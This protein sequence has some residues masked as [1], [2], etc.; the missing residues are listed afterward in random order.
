[1]LLKCGVGEDSFFLLLLFY[2][3][4][5][6]YIIVLV[7]PNIKMNPSQVYMCSPSWTLLPPPSPYHPSGSS[8]CTSPKHPV[9][10]LKISPGCL[11]EGLML[12]LKTP[13]LWPPDAKSWLIWKDPDAGKDWGQEGKGTTEDEM[14]GW[15]HWLNGHGFGWTLGVGNG[16]RGLAWYGSWGCKES[17]TTERLNWT[18]VKVP[19]FESWPHL[20]LW[21]DLQLLSTLC[22]FL[23]CNFL[24]CKMAMLQINC[25]IHLLYWLRIFKFAIGN[26][27]ISG[28]DTIHTFVKQRQ[29]SNPWDIFDI[30]VRNINQKGRKKQVGTKYS[31]GTGGT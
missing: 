15:H 14:V 6:L 3:I 12:K 5:K 25:N 9:P 23:I 27:K 26:K 29:I 1:M 18:G 30:C 16:Q 7:L 11:L 19:E 4:F 24:I 13:I 2:F 10:I 20:G 17:D 28:R 8:Q 31:W 21:Q 22:N